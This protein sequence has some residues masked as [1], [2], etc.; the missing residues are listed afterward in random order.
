[1]KPIRYCDEYA[2]IRRL[3]AALAPLLEKVEEPKYCM[4][5]RD[6]S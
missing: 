1:M 5:A 2:P 4:K 3:V 6:D